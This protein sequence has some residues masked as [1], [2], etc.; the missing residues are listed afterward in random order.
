M[1]FVYVVV[2]ITP[3]GI[4]NLGWRFY[5]IF[6]FFNA[7]FLPAVWYFYLETAGLTLEQIDCVFEINYESGGSISLKV[8][9]KQAI[10]ETLAGDVTPKNADDEREE[11]E[12]DEDV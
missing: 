10:A 7:A 5:L 3:I 8:A 2:L 9:R 11:V 6:G 1:L 12:H 4:Q